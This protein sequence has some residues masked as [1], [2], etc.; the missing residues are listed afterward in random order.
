MVRVQSRTKT[1]ASV[2]DLP[3]ASGSTGTSRSQPTGSVG[4]GSGLLRVVHRTV[5][6]ALYVHVPDTDP[7]QRISRSLDSPLAIITT[8]A[9][10]ERAG[11]LIGFHAQSSIDPLNYTVWLSKANHTYRVGLRAS[12]FAVHFLSVDQLPLATHFG[13]MSG[14]TAD[15]FAP[16]RWTPASNGVPL[17]R[18]CPNRILLERLA[19][20][21]DGGDHVCL[22]TGVSQA[23]CE[24]EF[25]P[26]R[27]SDA[28]HLEAGHDAAERA[29][30]PEVR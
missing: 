24:R 3:H 22:T 10:D 14:E 30:D 13:S 23:W 21:D 18:E 11:C 29:I 8:I 1:H 16:V 25:M 2:R 9:E 17:L 28:R 7:M 12:K 4:V 20:L 6:Y 19:V 15:K 26:L 27:Q 5:G